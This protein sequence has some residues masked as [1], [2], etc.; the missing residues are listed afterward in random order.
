MSQIFGIFQ[1]VDHEFDSLLGRHFFITI[2]YFGDVS[3]RRCRTK[4]RLCVPSRS[5]QLNYSLNNLSFSVQFFLFIDFSLLILF[6]IRFLK[7]I[8]FNLW[9]VDVVIFE[10]I[11]ER[12]G[13]FSKNQV[14]IH[15]FDPTFIQRIQGSFVVVCSTTIRASILYSANNRL[16][17]S[18]DI[19]L[20]NQICADTSSWAAQNLILLLFFMVVDMAVHPLEGIDQLVRQPEGFG[21]QKVQT[22]FILGELSTNPERLVRDSLRNRLYLR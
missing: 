14:W 15:L 8:G 6:Y 17:C 7:L 13:D 10:D 5:T 20:R 19:L 3:E 2:E 18:N 16:L 1:H 11:L 22:W 12:F 4:S 9:L 21:L